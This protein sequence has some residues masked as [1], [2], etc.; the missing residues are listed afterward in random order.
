MQESAKNNQLSSR[1]QVE[2]LIGDLRRG[3]PVAVLDRAGGLVVLAVETATPAQLDRVQAQTPHGPLLLLTPERAQDLKIGH[4]G[5]AAVAI[6][7]PDWLDLG[8]IAAIADPSKDLAA[9]LKGPLKR[10]E[11]TADPCL[12]AALVLT[13]LAQLLPAA[14][15]F[16]LPDGTDARA[17]AQAQDMLSAPASAVL[18]HDSGLAAALQAVVSARLPLA[19]APKARVH[20]FRPADGGAEHLAIVIGDPPRH[21]PVLVRLHSECLTGDLLG[22]LKCDCGDQLRGAIA[23]IGAAG[24]GVLL[25]LAQE[26]RGIGLMNKLR[27]YALQDQ[28]FDT[29]DA[30]TK[31]GFRADE[32]QFGPAAAML[33]ALG[34]QEIRLMTNN[35]AKVAG[36][37]QHGLRVVER[38]PHQFP[39]N[40]HNE[41]YL[42][43]K[44]SR[45]GHLLD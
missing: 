41:G 17:W 1:R 11:R 24:A 31:L 3:E 12:S 43:V 6:A 28:G 30:N 26:G 40:V 2:R 19:G 18:S 45:T 42:A 36:L 27:A 13:K 5:R 23:A 29:V 16:A 35:P 20:A 4:K 34:F 7:W 38:V 25:Y 22:S 15:V 39:S 44:K 32:R 21:E 37:E 9:P 10:L 8:G 14:I 33:R